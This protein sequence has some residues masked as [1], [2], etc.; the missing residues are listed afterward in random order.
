MCCVPRELC[1]EISRDSR[2][3]F[4]FDIDVD[5]W[6]RLQHVHQLCI[7]TALSNFCNVTMS[8]TKALTSQNNMTMFIDDL[9]EMRQGSQLLDARQPE[10]RT[11]ADTQHSQ[12]AQFEHI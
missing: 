10:I 9:H 8:R 5:S 11:A 12:L 7:I 3:N 6:L 2:R 1:S 4:H